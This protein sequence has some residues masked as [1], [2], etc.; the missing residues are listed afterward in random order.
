MLVHVSW[1]CRKSNLKVCGRRNKYKSN[2][3][4]EGKEN[5]LGVM[6]KK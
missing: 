3:N 2:I 4:K 5:K 6:K 1:K